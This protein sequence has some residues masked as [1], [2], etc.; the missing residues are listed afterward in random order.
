MT[1]VGAPMVYY[2]TEAGMWGAD[3]PCDRM[4]MVWPD[5][6]YEPQQAH[7]L[8]RER[9]ADEVGFDESL[10][11]FYQSAIGLR[12]HSAALRRGIIEFVAA[13]DAAQ[14]LAFR[15]ANETE[16]LFIGLNRGG[17]T[18][19]W[20]VPV[21]R[22]PPSRRF[23]RRRA[24]SGSFPSIARPARQLSRYRA[25]TA[26]CFASRRQNEHAH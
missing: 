8:G 14:F 9:P 22:A 17:E 13:D 1:Y 7:P 18:Y 15:R 4:P 16:S 25:A 21:A 2:G 3:D 10:F 19:R 11:G 6:V 23:S 24:T 12:R 20:E 26:S 5:T